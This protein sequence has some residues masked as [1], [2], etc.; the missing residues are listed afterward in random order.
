MTKELSV[1][2]LLAERWLIA[3]IESQIFRDLIDRKKYYISNY[4]KDRITLTP[5]SGLHKKTEFEQI[6]SIPH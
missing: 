4:K 2:Q 6:A 3:I 5:I 1:I